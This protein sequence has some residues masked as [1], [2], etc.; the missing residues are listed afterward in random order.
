MSNANTAISMKTT[1]PL[2]GRSLMSQVDWQLIEVVR[3][4]L[5]QALDD[6]K[7]NLEQADTELQKAIDRN[8]PITEQEQAAALANRRQ[9]ELDTVVKQAYAQIAGAVSGVNLHALRQRFPTRYGELVQALRVVQD[10]ETQVNTDMEGSLD[11][12]T[13][14]W[15]TA[16][17]RLD[18]LVKRASYA[19]ENSKDAVTEAWEASRPAAIEQAR[20]AIKV[21]VDAY[22]Q[23]AEKRREAARLEVRAAEYHQT[24]RESLHECVRLLKDAH[25][26]HVRPSMPNV[27]QFDKLVAAY[28]GVGDPMDPLVDANAGQ[29]EAELLQVYAKALEAHSRS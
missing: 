6:A 29:F 23:A 8:D 15:E 1:M 5:V 13:G 25:G 26:R 20:E 2:A 19:L 22:V 12:L 27:T 3:P 14:H 16:K 28:A 21:A 7:A 17:R 9:R 10:L 18:A 4:D 11:E 24:V